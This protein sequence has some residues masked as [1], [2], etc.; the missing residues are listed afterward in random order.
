MFGRKHPV[1]LY[2]RDVPHQTTDGGKRLGLE[3][4]TVDKDTFEVFNHVGCSLRAPVV[5]P[6]GPPTYSLWSAATPY[7]LFIPLLPSNEPPLNSWVTMMGHRF[8]EQSCVIQSRIFCT[9]NQT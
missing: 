3:F 5:G 6:R 8:R 2:H 9:I 7:Y 1:L 4:A